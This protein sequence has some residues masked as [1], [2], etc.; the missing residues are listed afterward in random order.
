LCG[1]WHELALPFFWRLCT[2]TTA[3]AAVQVGVTVWHGRTDMVLWIWGSD[4]TW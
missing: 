1:R 3:G 2:R 4:L